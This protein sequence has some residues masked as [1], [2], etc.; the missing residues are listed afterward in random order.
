[1][2]SV[3]WREKTGGMTLAEKVESK[4]SFREGIFSIPKENFPQDFLPFSYKGERK[5]DK[6]WN[7]E[8]RRDR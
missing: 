8:R 6:P 4:K 3:D 1:M 5:T 7:Q 2:L